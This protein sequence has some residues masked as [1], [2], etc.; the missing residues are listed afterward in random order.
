MVQL[1][2]V[3]GRDGNVEEAAVGAVGARGWYAGREQ[4]D[5]ADLRAEDVTEMINMH[6]MISHD[7]SDG[8]ECGDR[9]TGLSGG[10]RCLEALLNGSR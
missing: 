7:V 1:T 10:R 8:L 9:E 5:Q 4:G 6:S 2:G 3:C